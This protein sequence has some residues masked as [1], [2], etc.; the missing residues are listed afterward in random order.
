MAS[1]QCTMI[2]LILH[3]LTHS[4][5]FQLV[6]QA[7]SRNRANF[8]SAQQDGLSVSFDWTVLPL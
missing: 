5:F 7:H 6:T 2:T 4:R 1:R 3:S 8:D